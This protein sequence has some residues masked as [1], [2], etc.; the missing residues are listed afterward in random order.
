[1][2]NIQEPPQAHLEK[3]RNGACPSNFRFAFGKQTNAIA[4]QKAI[5]NLRQNVDAYERDREERAREAEEQ[6]LF[7]T[8]D[9]TLRAKE[10]IEER[11]RE[12]AKIYQRLYSRQPSNPVDGETRRRHNNRTGSKN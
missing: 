2:I 7:L 4:A 8:L 3:R 1:M 9:V 5:W 11:T 12:A 6:Q 10:F